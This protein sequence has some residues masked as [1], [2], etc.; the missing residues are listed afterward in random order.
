MAGERKKRKD[1]TPGEALLVLLPASV[2]ILFLDPF[3]H[4]R[5]FLLS[6]LGAA[7]WSLFFLGRPPKA[8]LAALLPAL[9]GS[10][11]YGLAAKLGGGDPL[12]ALLEVGAKALPLCLFWTWTFSRLTL[13]SLA[14]WIQART[15]FRVLPQLLVTIH[16]MVAVLSEETR[17]K[18]RALL[19][20][21]P[22]LRRGTRLRTLLLLSA[23]LAGSTARRALASGRAMEARGYRGGLPLSAPQ[24]TRP[25][26][27]HYLA[28]LFFFLLLLGGLWE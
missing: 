8:S 3:S 15:P 22:R 19:C 11:G 4:F 24:R 2:E 9:G 18:R 17:T 16:R 23:A 10:A 1:L 6:L 27:V 13:P 25:A 26:P 20:R 12:R 21:A 28:A 14:R 7:A 5:L